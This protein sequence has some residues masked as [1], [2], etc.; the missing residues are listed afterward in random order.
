[1]S[2]AP[3]AADTMG[4]PDGRRTVAPPTDAPPDLTTALAA[5]TADMNRTASLEETLEAIVVAARGS[6]PDID[7]VAVTLSSRDGSLA[8]ATATDDLARRLDQVQYD[9]HQGPCV[10]AIAADTGDLVVLDDARHAG[11]W[12][13]FLAGAVPL[14]LRSAAAVRLFVGDR[15]VGVLNMYSTTTDRIHPETRTTAELFA[16]HAAHAYGHRHQV[17]HLRTALESRELVGNAVGI[18]MERY[19]LDRERAFQYLV[20]VAATSEVKLRVVAQELVGGP[21]S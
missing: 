14:G 6:M 2:P 3:A 21:A 13:R 4:P 11:E 16:I 10:T 19:G 12:H 17:D 1:M 20:R 5:A 18:V 9:E 15:T 8:T 7:H